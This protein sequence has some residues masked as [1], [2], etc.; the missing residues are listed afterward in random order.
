MTNNPLP[1]IIDSVMVTP[2]QKYNILI[3][4]LQTII[5]ETV[6]VARMAFIEAYHTTGT[7]ILQDYPELD[8]EESYGK[9]I[10]RKIARDVGKSQ[11]MIQRSVQIARAWPDLAYL[12]EEEGK[13]ISLNKLINKYL[14]AMSGKGNGPTTYYDGMGQPNF[15]YGRWRITLPQ[16]TK[17]NLSDDTT[18]LHIIIKE[19]P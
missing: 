10:T 12:P 6:Y 14:P 4:E 16:G 8:T 17:L 18:L 11:R 19:G 9:G 2:S 3:D 1:T 7:R 15:E 5:V 13:N